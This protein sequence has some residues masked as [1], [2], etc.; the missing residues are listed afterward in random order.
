M[1]KLIGTFFWLVPMAVALFPAIA[2][3]RPIPT[4]H[5]ETLVRYHR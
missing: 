1:T 2:A 5:S 4:N 3:A